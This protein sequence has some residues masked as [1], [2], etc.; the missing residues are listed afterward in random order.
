MEEKAGLGLSVLFLQG[1][2][3]QESENGEVSWAAEVCTVGHEGLVT[4]LEKSSKEKQ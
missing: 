2:R 1:V 3:V 4:S